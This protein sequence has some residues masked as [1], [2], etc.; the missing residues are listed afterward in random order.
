M[1]NLPMKKTIIFTLSLSTLL[2]SCT[3]S[4][5]V[6]DN[7]AQQI[8]DNIDITSTSDEQIGILKDKIETL[9]TTIDQ[10]SFPNN[11]TYA[12]SQDLISLSDRVNEIELTIMGDQT[13]VEVNAE[14]SLESITTHE[15]SL[16]SLQIQISVIADQINSIKGDEGIAGVVTDLDTLTSRLDTSS[17]QVLTNANLIN[18]FAAQI[19]EL[20]SQ[21]DQLILDLEA[22]SNNSADG[23]VSIDGRTV[24][25]GFNPNTVSMGPAVNWY[26]DIDS[27]NFPATSSNY[28]GY[29][30]EENLVN[31]DEGYYA[32]DDGFDSKTMTLVPGSLVVLYESTNRT[33]KEISIED[34]TPSVDSFSLSSG[35]MSLN[36]QV[37]ISD[38]L[39]LVIRY[40]YTNN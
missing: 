28:L 3:V 30:S 38:V 37:S 6:P 19:E 22:V 34:I 20:Q 27:V 2:M 25:Y 13:K 9:T 26:F 14:S 4:L 21:V 33:T 31:Y 35:Y 40:K 29:V 23:D 12:T 32:N 5:E 24:F 39:Q 17:E 1:Y 10:Q 15:M 16:E 18:G 11:S 8:G 7:F 36:N